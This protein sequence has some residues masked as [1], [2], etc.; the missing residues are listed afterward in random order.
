MAATP[1]AWTAAAAL[2]AL[3]PASSILTSR[4]SLVLRDLDA[5]QTSKDLTW[6]GSVAAILGVLLW[7]PRAHGFREAVGCG[8]GWWETA[9]LVVVAG[10][11]GVGLTQA[12]ALLQP[13]SWASGGLL[14]HMVIALHVGGLAMLS[15][16][17]PVVRRA[18]AWALVG[19]LAGA[20]VL[21]LG[22]LGPVLAKATDAGVS[23][24]ST[25]LVVAGLWIASLPAWSDGTEASR[26]AES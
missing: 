13:E 8:R 1:L 10:M 12:T 14:D 5:V 19:F 24:L 17:I 16:S 22:T 23:N 26:V 3:A 18:P 6:L 25:W 9:L 15:T 2:I 4:G 7:L 21:S 11:A 20:E